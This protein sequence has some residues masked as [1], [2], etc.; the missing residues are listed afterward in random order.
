[1][2]ELRSPDTLPAA[3]HKS[4]KYSDR[5]VD[6]VRVS[7]TK[8]RKSDETEA[9]IH[10]MGTR[11]AGSGTYRLRFFENYPTERYGRHERYYGK[12]P[13]LRFFERA[14]NMKRNE[15]V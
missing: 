13:A 15:A 3:F 2:T 5:L 10:I 11:K 4:S 6:A 12:L 1:M 9:K 14:V 8:N 7:F